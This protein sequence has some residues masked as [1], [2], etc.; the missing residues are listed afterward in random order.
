[1]KNAKVI[2]LSSVATAL[3]VI[4]L[5]IGAYVEMFD[6]SCLFLA[7]VVIMIPLSKKYYLGAFLTCVA[8]SLLALLLTGARF[9]VVIP[10]AM[11]FGLHPIANQLQQKYNV[12]KILALIVKTAWFIGT[13]YVMYFITT[14][15][16]VENEIIAKYIHFVLIIGGGVGFFIYDYVMFCFQKTLDIIITKRLKF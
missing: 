12:N 6:L 3:C 8:S 13:L 15:F 7:S 10:F 14:M 1:M 11:F 4:L 5:S 16:V 9:Q 2:A